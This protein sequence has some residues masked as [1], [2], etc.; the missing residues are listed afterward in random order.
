MKSILFILIFFITFSTLF[1]WQEDDDD[2]TWNLD[3]LD[4][5]NLD[6]EA[7]FE[8]KASYGWFPTIYTSG[9]SY[10]FYFSSGDIYDEAQITNSNFL[11][12]SRLPLIAD[13]Q[14]D[15]DEKTIRKAYSKD[16]DED[17]PETSYGEV[18][19]GL[20]LKMTTNNFF[21]LKLGYFWDLSLL[22]AVDRSKR[23]LNNTGNIRMLKEA[24]LLQLDE[25]GIAFNAG[26]EIPIYGVFASTED[27]DLESF[28]H[29]YG[30]LSGS[31]SFISEASQY[32]Q[33]ANAKDDL[34]YNN[35]RDTLNLI[36]EQQLGNIN[37]TKMRFEFGIGSRF[38]MDGSGFGFE[39][40]Y[41]YPITSLFNDDRWLQHII[42][43][44]LSIFINN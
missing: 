17:G 29:I 30:G 9:L 28:Y 4:Y 13:I 16:E 23:F 43:F 11:A 14:M 10:I 37:L 44:D 42:K 39:I 8:F 33:I 35:G 18:G 6:F 27:S 36:N 32:L 40:T 41:S 5:R 21:R 1:A 26:F 25:H 15:S 3:T 19:L 34:R 20:R 2:A 38:L 22:G 31:H 7:D 24:N 12:P